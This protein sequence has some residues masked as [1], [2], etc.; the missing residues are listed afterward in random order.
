MVHLLNAIDTQLAPWFKERGQGAYR[1]E[2][3]RRWLFTRR[4][5]DFA[6]MTDLP[7]ALR[8]ELA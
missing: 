8:D 4:A 3:V 2:Q 6:A 5:T 7:Q 1:V